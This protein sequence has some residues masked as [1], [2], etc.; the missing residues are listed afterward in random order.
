MNCKVRALKKLRLVVILVSLL[1]VLASTVVS[2]QA[3]SADFV[4]RTGN[5]VIKGKIYVSAD[6]SRFE[7]DD[8]ITVSRMD[9]QVVWVLIPS[10]KMYMEQKLTPQNVVPSSETV[11]GEVERVHLGTETIDGKEAAKYRVF[12]IE[13]GKKDSFLLWLG[14]EA[15]LPLKMAAEDG[16]WVQEY[17]NLVVGPQP[18]SLFEVPAGYEKFSMAGMF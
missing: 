8:A 14:T 2:A 13:G 10:Q 15:G 11:A 12:V 5:D 6:K 9:K 4:S 3:F 18:D 1:L 7:M 16:S 17:K